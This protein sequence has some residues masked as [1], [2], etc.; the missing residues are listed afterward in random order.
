MQTEGIP[1]SIS[2]YLDP[3]DAPTCSALTQHKGSMTQIKSGWTEAVIKT[4]ND[5]NVLII[6]RIL[7]K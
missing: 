1:S 7:Q 5:E 6:I 3:R 4:D 2:S